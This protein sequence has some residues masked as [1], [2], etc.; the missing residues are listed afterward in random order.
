MF[1]EWNAQGME[2]VRNQLIYVAYNIQVAYG[3]KIYK[4]AS[5]FVLFY[6]CLSTNAAELLV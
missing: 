2:K 1:I 5:F 4:F 6:V 3:V